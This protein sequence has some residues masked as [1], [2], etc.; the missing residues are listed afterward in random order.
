MATALFG[1]LHWAHLPRHV[2]AY[3]GQSSRPE[4]KAK[5][6]LDRASLRFVVNTEEEPASRDSGRQ[7]NGSQ[8]WPVSGLENTRHA[9]ARAFVAQPERGRGVRFLSPCAWPVN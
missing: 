1:V 4:K 3:A 7:S 6:A 2:F 5:K 9:N 8:Y